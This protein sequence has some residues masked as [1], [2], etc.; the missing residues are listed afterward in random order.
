MLHTYLLL[1]CWWGFKIQ[2]YNMNYRILINA[3]HLSVLCLT[4]SPLSSVYPLDFLCFSF[5]HSVTSCFFFLTPTSSPLSSVVFEATPF[6]F[7]HPSTS[8]LLPGGCTVLLM[9]FLLSSPPPTCVPLPSIH[10]FLNSF[11]LPFPPWGC[12]TLP[13]HFAL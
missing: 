7:S 3:V 5:Y 11:Q 6:P 4:F 1:Q 2:S 9:S 13:A 10:A 12:V 8:F